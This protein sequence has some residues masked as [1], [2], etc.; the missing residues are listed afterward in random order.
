M[1]KYKIEIIIELFFSYDILNACFKTGTQVY[2]VLSTK[3]RGQVDGLCGNFDGLS[4]NEFNRVSTGG[5]IPSTA[6]DFSDIFKIQPTCPDLTLPANF[7]PCAVRIFNI[8]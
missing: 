5:I 8:N 3:Y 4:D 6:L 1:C 2:I 7:D